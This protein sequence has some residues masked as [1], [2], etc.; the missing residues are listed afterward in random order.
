MGDHFERKI[1]A[2]AV[3][4]SARL[5]QQPLFAQFAGKLGAARFLQG[6]DRAL[7]LAVHE[8]DGGKAG[9]DLGARGAVQAVVDLVLEQFGRLVEQVDGDQPVG[10]APDHLV[11]AAADRRQFAIIVE[12]G[13]RLDRLER[14]AFGGEE[15]AVEGRRRLVL[16]LARQLGIGMRQHGHAHDVEGVAVA[17]LLRIEMRQQLEPLDLGLVAAPDGGERLQRED[18]IRARQRAASPAAA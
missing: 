7:R 3:G 8:V 4:Q 12:Y 17:P 1:V 6:G 10:Q 15:Q 9:R 2:A 5:Q 13:Q 14:V 18:R 11:A 16:D